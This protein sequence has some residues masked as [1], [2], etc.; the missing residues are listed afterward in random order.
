V[1]F[2]SWRTDERRVRLLHFA[3][4]PSLRSWLANAVNVNYVTADI[5]QRG[6]STLLDMTALGVRD[7]AFDVVVASHVL[8]HVEDDHV[9]MCELLRILRPGGT[10]L[11]MV[12]RDASLAV[13]FEDPTITTPEARQ[14][15]YRQADHV[16]LY[17]RD[18]EHRL[19]S[20]G[21]EVELVRPS[22]TMPGSD[23]RRLGLEADPVIYRKYGSPPP[24]EIYVARRPS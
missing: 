21:F 9:A 19:R 1:F 3:P 14:A 8:E 20:A 5:A 24:D 18:F 7:Q 13:T 10:A 15:A 22:L 12:P 6:V 23:A 4:E 16:R 2:D 17:G 11:V